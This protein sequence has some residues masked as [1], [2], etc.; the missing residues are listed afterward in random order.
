MW[1]VRPTWVSRPKAS[2]QSALDA[3]RKAAKGEHCPKA[4]NSEKRGNEVAGAPG[5]DRTPSSLKFRQRSSGPSS[6]ARLVPAGPLASSEVGVAVLCLQGL[7]GGAA[8]AGTTGTRRMPQPSRG[9]LW[10]PGGHATL[11]TWR[12]SHGAGPLRGVRGAHSRLNR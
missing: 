1:P 9:P 5:Q 11:R 6:P 3:I 2:A 10:P 8:A 7:T 12:P 4:E